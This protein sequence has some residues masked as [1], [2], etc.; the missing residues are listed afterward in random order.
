MALYSKGQGV[1][2]NNAWH[3]NDWTT[4]DMFV[5]VCA[6]LATGITIGILLTYAMFDSILYCDL[7]DL[8]LK[9]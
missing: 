8:L 6:G 2:P 7:L 5:A 3:K 9:E 1:G 4:A